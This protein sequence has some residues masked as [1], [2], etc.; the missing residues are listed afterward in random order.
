[1]SERLALTRRGLVQAAGAAIGATVAGMPLAA[2]SAV[3]DPDSALLDLI[4]RHA[5]V[6]AERA[7]FQDHLEAAEAE[8]KDALPARPTTLNERFGDEFGVGRTLEMLPDGRRRGYFG[9]DQIEALRR[10]PS[11]TWRHW[12]S[13]PAPWGNGEEIRRYVDLPDP[14]RAAPPD[15]PRSWQPMTHGRQRSRRSPIGSA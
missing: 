7:A 3:P 14:R 2:H 9:S 10:L 8:F 6:V 13:E 1:M 4:A 11:P 5:A 12:D 15:W